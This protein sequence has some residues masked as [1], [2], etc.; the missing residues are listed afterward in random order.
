MYIHNSGLIFIPNDFSIFAVLIKQTGN[1]D[2]YSIELARCRNL[3]KTR[4]L[5]E[6]LRLL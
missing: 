1:G 4:G 2:L 5:L 6:I 3:L